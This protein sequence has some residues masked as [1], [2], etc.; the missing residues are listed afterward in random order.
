VALLLGAAAA[1][2]GGGLTVT[3]AQAAAVRPAVGKPLEAAKADVAA[4]N[5]SAAMAHVRQAEAVGGLTAEEKSVIAQMKD[6]IASRSGGTV[7]VSNAIG[8]QAKFSA[9]YRAGRYRDVIEDMDLL[10]KYGILNGSNLQYVA[11]AYYHLGEYRNCVRIARDS[12]SSTMLELQV[13]CA[14]KIGDDEAARD[15]L[16]R[17]VASTGRAEYWNR[18]LS[19]AERAKALS[20]HQSLDIYRLRLLTGSMKGKD[21]YFVLATLTLQPTINCPS[22]AVSVIE[23][24]MQAKVLTDG[25][26]QR[27]LNQAKGVMAGDLADLQRRATEANKAKSGDDLVKLGEDYYGM[28]RYQDALDAVQA[29]IKKGVSDDDNAQIRLGLAYYGVGQK[30]AALKTFAKVTG[31]PNAQMV[32]RLWSVYVRGH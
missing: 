15:A 23:K 7:G 31:S 11:Q 21:D 8:A 14:S 10:R 5:Y 25:R 2:A 30:D 26:A 24:G 6:Y 9:D 16:E 32:A 1:V 13:T 22:E 17:L 12:G 3:S 27:L 18:L 29:G 19:A 4:H 28:G 20:D